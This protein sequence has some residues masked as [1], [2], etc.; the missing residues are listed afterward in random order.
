MLDGLKFQYKITEVIVGDAK[1]V[2]EDVYL[3]AISRSLP[4][5]KVIAQWGVW[6]FAAGPMRNSAMLLQDPDFVIAFPGG[7]GTRD[8]IRQASDKGKTV[9]NVG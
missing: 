6:G 5:T 7:R 9:I 2:D 3:W 1:G 4:V 8:M